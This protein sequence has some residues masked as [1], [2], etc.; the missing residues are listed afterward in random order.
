MESGVLWI[1][2]PY[3]QKGSYL[4]SSS[5][6]IDGLVFREEQKL[7]KMI[8][9][10][11]LVDFFFC[12][13][14]TCLSKTKVH[15]LSAPGT[16]IDFAYHWNE[17]DLYR[18]YSCLGLER[19]VGI[20]TCFLAQ[21]LLYTLHIMLDSTPTR[22]QYTNVLRFFTIAISIWRSWLLAQHS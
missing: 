16:W 22:Y 5:E 12:V 14:R 20:C 6:R 21:W 19:E 4:V 3:L 2:L 15:L 17:H 7:I 13:A 11:A 18:S 1:P 9:F 10:I 8:S